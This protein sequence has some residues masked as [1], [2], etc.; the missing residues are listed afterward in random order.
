M[1]NPLLQISTSKGEVTFE[2]TNELAQAV[3]IVL[4]AMG[5]LLV[6]TWL[7]RKAKSN[8]LEREVIQRAT[9]K[10]RYDE[11]VIAAAERAVN[12]AY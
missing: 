2:N 5:G 6:F 9:L 11:D 7:R 10:E 4:T 1:S 12:E 8:D 3:G